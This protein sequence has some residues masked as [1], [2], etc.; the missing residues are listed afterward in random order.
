ML[1]ED[2]KARLSALA[3]RLL[4]EFAPVEGGAPWDIQLDVT[5]PDRRLKDYGQEWFELLEN[6]LKS[7]LI[8]HGVREDSEL[9]RFDFD[10]V[11]H[12][13]SRS[14]NI[15]PGVAL[16]VYGPAGKM[17][18]EYQNAQSLDLHFLPLRKDLVASS[19]RKLHWKVEALARVAGGTES[20]HSL[21]LLHLRGPDNLLE[22]R[23]RSVTRV[24]NAAART[25]NPE[26]SAL[27]IEAFIDKH[28][29]LVFENSKKVTVLF[30]DVLDKVRALAAD[31]GYRGELPGRARVWEDGRIEE[32]QAA[33]GELSGRPDLMGRQ[34]FSGFSLE[35]DRHGGSL[36]IPM[37]PWQGEQQSMAGPA[38]PVTEL[39]SAPEAPRPG[40]VSNSGGAQ[41]WLL[42]AAKAA[43][44][45]ADVV[46]WWHAE[47]SGYPALSEADKKSMSTFAG[48]LLQRKPAEGEVPWDIQL[49]VAESD[50]RLAKYGKK[51]FELLSNELKSALMA[52]GVRED[53]ELLRFDFDHVKHSA[54][55]DSPNFPSVDIVVFDTAGQEIQEY[56]NAQSLELLFLPLRKD[57]VASSRRKLRWRIE[58]LARAVDR[59]ESDQSLLALKLR[60]SKNMIEGL[61]KSVTEE[62]K[63]A[64]R[65]VYPGKSDAEIKTFIEKRT[66]F[67]YVTVNK[68]STLFVDLADIAQLVPFVR[69]EPTAG[70][71][72]SASLE[73]VALLSEDE[74]NITSFGVLL[75]KN[76]VARPVGWE[77]PDARITVRLKS[78]WDDENVRRVVRN[79]LGGV[80]G[81]G[82]LEAGMA[83]PE[84]QGFAFT[85]S[86]ARGR[87]G[88]V[89]RVS[90]RVHVPA[91]EPPE[92]RELDYYRRAK[93]LTGKFLSNNSTRLSKAVER[94]VALAA[95]GFF[96]RFVAA[97]GVR[98]SLEVDINGH[99]KLG[100]A[101]QELLVSVVREA[102][103]A[104]RAGSAAPWGL[105]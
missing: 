50:H 12:S 11:K 13:A 78:G 27:E 43:R 96:D 58:G 102:L 98:P 41:G 38:W 32:I 37:L 40:T 59:A 14:K 33:P 103:L 29:E 79:Y 82:M 46:D 73:S 16:F 64:T 36:D 86:W 24:V 67:R 89:G 69:M 75:G 6:E 74:K 53:S 92:G 2:D 57:L 15:L 80:L 84:V 20:D 105:P 44:R 9:L 35:G 52:H 65:R 90:M 68:Y 100:P 42:N 97:A 60:G 94:R 71:L 21:L 8:A 26:A 61:T 83:E 85:W 91:G 19:R 51:W 10:H 5:E 31:S 81:K 63:E 48:R 101:R 25:A 54:R 93:A 30:V 95:E 18:Q 55:K 99:R 87:D 88:T 47:P 56:Q 77:A 70:L 3:A 45:D 23:V 22:G 104:R 72:G 28:I 49:H 66:T 34:A 76:I 39:P 4:G 62:I 1:S 17:I 7:A